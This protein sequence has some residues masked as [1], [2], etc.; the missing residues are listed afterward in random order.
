MGGSDSDLRIAFG[1]HWSYFHT[2][3]FRGD[4]VEG[5]D[6]IS[7]L[8]R[9]DRM[10]VLFSLSAGVY[11][12]QDSQE[13]V[14]FNNCFLVAETQDKLASFLLSHVSC[15]HSKIYEFL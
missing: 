8:S 10:R 13:F 12:L 2:M 7:P 4:L 6:F 14:L 11:N 5:D 1:Y 9:T 3:K 15:E